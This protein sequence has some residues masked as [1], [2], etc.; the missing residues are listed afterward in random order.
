MVNATRKQHNNQLMENHKINCYKFITSSTW[1]NSYSILISAII[2]KLF[3]LKL[4]H[5]A[6]PFSIHPYIRMKHLAWILLPLVVNTTRKLHNNQLIESHK[7]NCHKFIKSS[8]WNNSYSIIISTIIKM[9]S[10]EFAGD[11]ISKHGKCTCIG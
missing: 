4:E 5:N 3:Y 7:W 2:D 8:T 10:C 11:R 6:S 9:I 1:N